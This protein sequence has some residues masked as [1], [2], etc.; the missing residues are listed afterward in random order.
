MPVFNSESS[1]YS[2][3][4]FSWGKINNNS[5]KEYVSKFLSEQYQNDFS[6][7]TLA[8]KLIDWSGGNIFNADAAR[9]TFDQLAVTGVSLDSYFYY[10]AMI[11]I[12]QDFQVNPCPPNQIA[13]KARNFTELIN[14]IT[15]TEERLIAADVDDAEDRLQYIRGIYYG[16]PWSLDFSVEHSAVRNNLFNFFCRPGAVVF[17][18]P[19]DIRPHLNC[20]LFDALFASPEI[21]HSTS[22]ILDWGHVIIGLE[23]R[24]NFSSR[25]N[26]LVG[27]GGSG[28]A[29]N[30]WLGDLG[31]GAGTLAFRR[32]RGNVSSRAISVFGLTGSSFG[33]PI[34]LEGNVGAYLI[35]RE[36]DDPDEP[37]GP[38]DVS[39]P[40]N[41]ETNP[42][43]TI[44]SN[45]VG[46]TTPSA[47]WNNRGKLFLQML[48]GEFTGTTLTNR[49]DLIDDLAEQIETFG[50]R[51]VVL[52]VKDGVPAAQIPQT[53]AA[54]SRHIA[55]A[56][57]EVAS[58]FVDALVYTVAHPSEI[59]RYRTNPDPTPAGP[60]SAIF[61]GLQNII[62]RA[63]RN[64]NQYI[65]RARRL[66]RRIF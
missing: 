28:L 14:L 43:A 8:A 44:V 18:A 48:G 45:Y 5:T 63:D 57:K 55:G 2:Y 51:Y 20:G 12:A 38:T 22:R 27:F 17:D 9:K 19:D 33:A 47:D 41:N 42:I 16:T 15:R 52:R 10:D 1:S 54:I 49:N 46:T 59:I 35:G 4:D 40:E 61:Q 36:I 21:R 64:T 26:L 32:A 66:L 23:S 25:K 24:T 6:K 56:A 39:F 11:A 60:P 3:S 37:D 58:I 13:H 30:T 50:S 53:F 65:D 31:G 34:N 62:E 7:T 29:C